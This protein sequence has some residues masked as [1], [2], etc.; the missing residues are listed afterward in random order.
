MDQE[1]L[2]FNCFDEL[3]H[4]ALKN[5]DTLTT[6]T[7]SQM[8]INMTGISI[9]AKPRRD[10]RYQGYVVKPNSEKQYFYGR[11]RDDV[12]A[13]IKNYL[14]EAKTPKR[15]VQKKYSPTFGEYF[16]KWMNLYKKPT[17]KPTSIQNIN[18]SLKPALTKFSTCQIV[19]ITSDDVQE[20]LLSI[21]S[22]SMRDR[23]KI[24]LN[25]IFIK[26][27]KS[28]IIKSNPCDA[29]EIKKHKYK[30][31][32]GLTPKQQEEFLSYTENSK[33]SLLYRLLLCSG[34]RIGE[35]LALHKSDIDIENISISI[36]KDVVFIKSER[37]EQTPKT[38][39]AVRS[40]PISESICNELQAIQTDILFPY[41]YN[42]IRK[43]MA[44]IAKQ[45]NIDV[46]AHIL[47][48]TYSNRL[49]EAGIPPKVKQ[50][51]MGHAKLDTTQNIY[52]DTQ[53]HFVKAHEN[54][55]RKLF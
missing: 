10:G 38:E 51:L 12:A 18:D 41:T 2:D 47:R 3:M 43:A 29:V 11:S 9:N 34:I 15:K 16:E 20:L 22:G 6:P 1:I 42:A 39:A 49:E 46:T 48:H 45:L 28:G 40:I 7:E 55:I 53:I 44:E 27:V 35:A 31:K 17:L 52:T 36:T 14:Q 25:Q 32:V 19:K 4:E 23:C 30:H 26:A 13:K 24:N 33:Y 8:L 37:V 50:Y 21:S 54:N 5:G